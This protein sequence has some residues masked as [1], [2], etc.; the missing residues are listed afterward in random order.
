MA[1]SAVINSPD[2]WNQRFALD[3]T[4]RGGAEQTSFFAR[5]AI[6]ML[7]DFFWDDARKNTLSFVDVGCALGEALP[8]FR[9]RL[10]KNKLSGVDVSKVA[11]RMA[12][13]RLPNFTFRAVKED[14]S[15]APGGD[16]MFCS[17]TLEHL[18]DWKKRLARL[19]ELADKYVLMLVP[20]QE[21]ARIDEH[22]VSFDFTSF[23]AS[24]PDG[25]RLLYFRILDAAQA[26]D[27]HWPGHQ[28]LAI[29]GP[30]VGAEEGAAA[31]SDPYAGV[32]FRGRPVARIKAGLLALQAAYPGAPQQ[33]QADQ[34][35][36]L[37]DRVNAEWAQKLDAS[38]AEMSAK[39]AELRTHYEGVLSERDAK[40]ERS[41]NDLVAKHG[42]IKAHYE[43]VLGERDARITQLSELQAWRQRAQE[44]ETALRDN[45]SQ[46]LKR[47]QEQVQ[48]LSVQTVEARIEAARA[49]MEAEQASRFA[50]QAA[51]LELEKVRAALA[52]KER[53][54]DALR[55]RAAED[56]AAAEQRAEQ[57]LGAAEQLNAVVAASL[58]EAKKALEEAEANAEQAVAR[59]SMLAAA[60]NQL[61]DENAELQ[62]VIMAASAQA[63]VVSADTTDVTTAL[64]SE[65]VGALREELAAARALLAERQQEVEALKAEVK[66]AT[67]D[68]GALKAAI[69]VAVDERDQAR[70]GPGGP[71]G[72]IQELEA[73]LARAEETAVA[74]ERAAQ[75]A[76]ARHAAAMREL[77]GALDPALDALRRSWQGD[78]A[79][80]S[81]RAALLEQHASEL[82]TQVLRI[83]GSKSLKIGASL[84]RAYW[85]VLGQP[86]APNETAPRDLPASQDAGSE[87]LRQWDKAKRAAEGARREMSAAPSPVADVT[88]AVAPPPPPP[89]VVAQPPPP[90]VRSEQGGRVIALQAAS[91]GSGGLERVVFDLAIGLKARGETVIAICVLGGGA[92]ADD[93]RQRGIPV[94]EVYRDVA[95]YEAVLRENGVTDLFAHHSY[96]GYERA[97]SLGI[98][99]YD[100]VHNYYFWHRNSGN[101]I[102]RVA[103]LSTQLIYVSS[104]VRAFHE[105][106]FGVP[107]G[108][109]VVINNPVHLDGLI[110]PEK[111]QLQRLREKSADTIFLNVAQAF[112]SKAQPAMITAFARAYRKNRNMRL[113][114][115]GAPVKDEAARAV[116]ARIDAEG[117]GSAVELLG[118][119]DR[120]KM[121]RLYAEAHAFVLPSLYEGYSVSAIE[122]ATY[123]LPLIL[124]NVGG[125]EDLIARSGC[126]ILLPP[127][128]EDLAKLDPADVERLGLERE[129]AA[130]AAL[131]KAFADVAGD[132][133]Q[134]MARALAAH[135]DI[136]SLD[137]M[138]DAY[139]A[140]MPA[141]ARAGA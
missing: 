76:T 29:Y 59:A 48:T 67:A 30:K 71:P 120:R 19:G 36:A 123:A 44:L 2:Y 113:Q 116:H 118:H 141:A 70:A 97:A 39:H 128:T 53:E 35:Q 94:H 5:V 13:E 27:T 58:A 38:V 96:F 61:R 20:F 60:A 121:S 87:F 93:L 84:R 57:R 126:G 54:F 73:Q 43:R 7:P 33:S 92:F 127:A 1:D 18:K 28:A 17:N 74:S 10:P 6:A 12:K 104:A 37:V 139:A 55:A 91:L 100:V 21:W 77:V 50:Q 86:G 64:D 135:Y 134:W 140:A 4:A 95:T 23:P 41:V 112:P 11:I 138:I 133:P 111:T 26:P 124:T 14:W 79:R 34:A 105:R 45:L 99:L 114:I 98:R 51:A 117:V 103:E 81:G 65:A 25:K 80:L 82:H 132:R 136:R 52:D 8:D 108:K 101:M 75:E 78:Y 69:R 85:T 119:C 66:R 115:A 90:V 42:E 24:L 15:D 125:A 63:Q 3:W 137:E 49:K 122:A 40:L 16:I 72:R 88:R 9:E 131:E 56:L 102:R 68:H 89:L 107:P 22:V 83:L 46:Q 32:D 31:S 62:A 47:A 130:T 110:V 109:G 129:N 106:L